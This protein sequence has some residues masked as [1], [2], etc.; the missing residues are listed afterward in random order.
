VKL[1]TWGGSPG[2]MKQPNPITAIAVS[3]NGRFVVTGDQLGFVRVFEVSSKR[4]TATVKVPR[5]WVERYFGL[6]HVSVSDDGETVTS[7]S[8]KRLVT[9]KVSKWKPNFVNNC[10]GGEVSPDGTWIANIRNWL[11]FHDGEREF[12]A[13]SGVSASDLAFNS[14]GQVVVLGDGRA[15]GL[16][17]VMNAQ[18]KV[19]AKVEVPAGLHTGRVGFVDDETV[20][21]VTRDE[22]ALRV[23]EWTVGS[24]KV[25]SRSLPLSVELSP[26]LTLLAPLKIVLDG[27]EQKLIDLTSGKF[28]RDVPIGAQW[29][30]SA[31][32]SVLV[33]ADDT[34][35]TQRGTDLYEPF[36]AE[37]PTTPVRALA[38][39]K[40][41]EFAWAGDEQSFRR[42]KVKDGQVDAT[43]A[44]PK[45]WHGAAI[46]ADAKVALIRK[47]DALTAIALPSGKSVGKSQERSSRYPS[48]SADGSRSVLFRDGATELRKWS[49][50][51]VASWPIRTTAGIAFSPDGKWIV[52]GGERGELFFINAKTGETEREL[53]TPNGKPAFG[54]AF[55]ADG[56]LLALLCDAATVFVISV[57]DGERV[58]AL[59]GLARNAQ[60]PIVFSANGK[61]LAASDE[62]RTAVWS[63][64]TGKKAFAQDGRSWALAFSP[65]SKLLLL[66]GA[67]SVSALAL[68]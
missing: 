44:I 46:S 51:V 6:T 36:V 63:M 66:G 54:I 40:S 3:R 13:E 29:A 8:D 59:K 15:G 65:D 37:G 50:E 55:S 12:H 62:V 52:T 68:E 25:K 58:R 21:A 64:E 27:N 4:L 32:G 45:G 18:A 56:K 19:V 61:W 9:G 57:R 67:G 53:R 24:K 11:Y 10:D 33:S 14:K 23:V 20:L 35:I 7:F 43:V 2:A 47:E 60:W 31:D 42:W 26:Y 28:V 39:E 1:T 48:L 17:K 41:G 30:V 34:T 38:F 5:Q 22:K 16:L 49:G